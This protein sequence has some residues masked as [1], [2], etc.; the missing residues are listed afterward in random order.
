MLFKPSDQRPHIVIVCAGFGAYL[1]GFRSRLVVML[2]W[3]PSDMRLQRTARLITGV[4]DK[5]APVPSDGT[6]PSQIRK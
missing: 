3:A 5:E 6:A 1:I 2:N 4:I